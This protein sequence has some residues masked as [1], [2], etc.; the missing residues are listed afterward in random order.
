MLVV[1]TILLWPSSTASDDTL[2]GY[3]KAHPD[4]LLIPLDEADPS[5]TTETTNNECQAQVEANQKNGTVCENDGYFLMEQVLKFKRLVNPPKG[6]GL[7][8]LF[9]KLAPFG[10]PMPMP[11]MLAKP[12]PGK[13]IFLPEASKPPAAAYDFTAPAEQRTASATYPKFV[14]FEAKHV[15][16]QFDENDSEGIMREAKNRLKNTCDGKQLGQKWTAERIPQALDRQYPSND[17]FRETKLKDIR[18]S[19]FGR[20][21]FVCLLG[22]VGNPQLVR[23]YVLI[24]VVTSGMDLESTQ[25]KARKTQ[26]SGPAN[27][28]Y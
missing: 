11:T 23:L 19:R 27:N 13:L 6:K 9:E 18:A 24:D 3:R 22:P 12:K 4:E 20:W 1:V 26:P 14:V 15:S 5:A 28:E 10:E 2:D 7:D 17:T 25:P 16:K 21:I 8:G